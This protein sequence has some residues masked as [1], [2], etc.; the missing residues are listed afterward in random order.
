MHRSPL[1]SSEPQSSSPPRTSSGYHKPPPTTTTALSGQ[2]ALPYLQSPSFS[3]ASG[4][5]SHTVSP[6]DVFGDDDILRR[7]YESL[8]P[9]LLSSRNKPAPAP[10]SALAQAF[11]PPSSVVVESLSS[12]SPPVFELS[13]DS[14]DDDDV[15]DGHAANLSLSMDLGLAGPLRHNSQDSFASTSSEDEEEPH[16]LFLPEPS[17]YHHLAPV[18]ANTRSPPPTLSSSLGTSWGSSSKLSPYMAALNASSPRGGTKPLMPF[19]ERPINFGFAPLKSSTNSSTNVSSDAEH[20]LPHPPGGADNIDEA[21]W[22]VVEA[23]ARGEAIRPRDHSGGSQSR[24]TSATRRSTSATRATA[25]PTKRSPASVYSDEED[26]YRSSASDDSED[27]EYTDKAPPARARRPSGSQHP[28]SHGHHHIRNVST[29]ATAKVRKPR[30][31]HPPATIGAALRGRNLTSTA[32]DAGSELSSHDSP[33]PTERCTFQESG[34]SKVCGQMFVRSYDLR[35]HEETIHG[36]GTSTATDGKDGAAGAG[37]ERTGFW[38]LVCERQF[39]RK[40]AL[41]RHQ[42]TIVDWCVILYLLSLRFTNC[43]DTLSSLSYSSK[44]RTRRKR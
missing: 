40:D 41:I 28:Y 25:R 23:V 20:Q 32:K 36:M 33:L 42:K 18:I 19:T 14:D 39:S 4:S 9:S 7:S 29:P 26:S 27:D 35:R 43:T 1:L 10:S 16:A 31:S 37:G 2:G 24:S 13:E 5:T 8:F 12:S 34:S 22:S 6:R 11:L 44:S 38:C 30:A 3:D 17:G 15:D 21:A